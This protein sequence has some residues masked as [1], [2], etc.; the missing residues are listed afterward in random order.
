[1]DNYRSIIGIENGN[2]HYP[3]FCFDLSLL[4]SKDTSKYRKLSVNRP[5]SLI[6]NRIGCNLSSHD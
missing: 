1:M 2:F 6:M 3:S 5:T 4:K